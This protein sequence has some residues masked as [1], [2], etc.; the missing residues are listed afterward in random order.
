M[1]SFFSSLKS[2]FPLHN[3]CVVVALYIR[4]GQPLSVAV[5]VL[6]V[7]TIDYVLGLTNKCLYTGNYSS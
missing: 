2:T 5:C 3:F 7:S 1:W 4:G 6:V